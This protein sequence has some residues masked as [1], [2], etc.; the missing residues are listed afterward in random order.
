M[1][2]AFGHDIPRLSW[3]GA[4]TYSQQGDS[5]KNHSGNAM[6]HTAANKI[7]LVRTA[8]RLMNIERLD[9]T[10]LLTDGPAPV[11]VPNARRGARVPQVVYEGST[12]CVKI[13]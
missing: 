11:M 5:R 1:S 2:R 12:K 9:G 4:K 3:I 6:E 10:P 8:E 7:N 13:S